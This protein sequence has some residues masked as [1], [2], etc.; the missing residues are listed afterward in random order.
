MDTSKHEPE[1]SA[2]SDGDAARSDADGKSADRNQVFGDV[3]AALDRGRTEERFGDSVL[4]R[5]RGRPQLAD[6]CLL[7]DG[8]RTH[9][10][11]VA[12]PQGSKAAI[13]EGRIVD[14]ADCVWQRELG[15]GSQ[16]ARRGRVVIDADAG[17]RFVDEPDAG[18]DWGRSDE[19]LPSLERDLASSLRIMGLCRSD[20]FATLLYAA[21]CNTTWRHAATDMDWHCSWRSAGGVLAHIRGEGDYLDWYCNGGEGIV[22]ERVLAEIEQLGWTLVPE[23]LG[24]DEDAR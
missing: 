17:L 4:T 1:P 23:K 10:R 12:V 13:G 6:G 24:S 20:A 14:P 16:L 9:A 19:Q 22:D 21:L 18:D 15:H 5:M 3:F 7:P 8:T 2:A 11:C